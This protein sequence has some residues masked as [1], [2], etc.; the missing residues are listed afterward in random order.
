[1]PKG[2]LVAVGTGIK[3][4][5]HLTMEARSR[6]EQA[7]KV[8]YCVADT[9]T[10]TW[11]RELNPTSENLYVYYGDAKPRIRTYEDMVDR[12]LYFV[13]QGLNVCQ[14]FYGHP[15]VFV[16][17][18]HEAMAI[19]RDEGYRVEMLPGISAEDCLYADLSID[20]ATHGCQ[21]YEAT[22]F[23]IRRRVIDPTVPVILWQIG[24]VG[25][26]GYNHEG[27][28]LRGLPVLVEELQKVYGTD[29]EVVIYEAASYPIARPRI[30]VMKL[31][32]LSPSNITAISTMFIPPR[33][34]SKVD[35]EKRAIWREENAR[36]VLAS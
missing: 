11:I 5:A 4:I 6:I 12:T 34:A 2:S 28:E 17:A 20:P 24:V 25:E 3:A 23:L 29:Y 16:F 36:T 21:V 27:F 32:E 9:V 7:D 33:E 31:S 15:G 18:T 8:L 10:E 30:D 22:D 13:R 14:V 1:M 35:F 19:L 26:L